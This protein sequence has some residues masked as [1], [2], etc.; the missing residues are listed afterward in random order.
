MTSSAVVNRYAQALYLESSST[1]Q[2][3]SDVTVMAQ[4]LEGSRDL[5][6]CVASPVVPRAKK[7]AIVERLFA[8]R[9][10]PSTLKFLQL[11]LERQRENLLADILN[12]LQT[13]GDREAGVVAIEAQV[14]EPLSQEAQAQLAATLESQL[15]QSVRLSMVHNKNLIGGIVLRIA[16]TVYDGSVRFQLSMLRKRMHV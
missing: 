1:Q 6:L 10:H 12:Q 2:L 16:D 15:S 4:L 11:L 13:L 3:Q 7:A 14:A 5:R 8:P 9:V